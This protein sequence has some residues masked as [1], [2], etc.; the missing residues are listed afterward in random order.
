VVVISE[1]GPQLEPEYFE[2]LGTVESV[3]ENITAFERRCIGAINLLKSE[4]RKH[5]ADALIHANCG[6]A[7]G[8]SRASGVAITFKNRNESLKRLE[9][10]GAVIK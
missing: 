6:E 1:Q 2:V 8:S 9:E 7:M 10:V 5:G 3:V 4:A